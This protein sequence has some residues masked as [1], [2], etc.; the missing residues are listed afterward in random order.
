[1]AA[2]SG[3]PGELIRYAVIGGVREAAVTEPLAG[4][5]RSR[6]AF[7]VHVLATA[8]DFSVAVDGETICR[9]SDSRLPAGG[10]GFL[11]DGED[12]ARLYWVR[13][14]SPPSRPPVA[15]PEAQIG[16]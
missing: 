11:A 12:R 8:G 9:W 15:A 1:V 5:V 3:G 7:T 10:V 4:R 13:L 6:A 14:S 16:V 2:T